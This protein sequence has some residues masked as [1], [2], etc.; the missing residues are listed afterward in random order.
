MVICTYCE[1]KC[2]SMYVIKVSRYGTYNEGM[3]WTE[4]LNIQR[5]CPKRTFIQLTSLLQYEKSRNFCFSGF[6]A[7]NQ[8]T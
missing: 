3:Q 1:F 8:F 6:I 7:T 5:G 4:L 2:I